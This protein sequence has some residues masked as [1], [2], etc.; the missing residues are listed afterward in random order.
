MK[1]QVPRLLKNK[2]QK[3]SR[4]KSKDRKLVNIETQN[5]KEKNL[6]KLALSPENRKSRSTKNL[7]QTSNSIA[8]TNS[9]EPLNKK[10]LKA[11]RILSQFSN[12]DRFLPEN[13]Q[14]TD[15]GKADLQANEKS[16]SKKLPPVIKTAKLAYD[17]ELLRFYEEITL[18]KLEKDE[19]HVFRVQSV[20]ID[21]EQ[22]VKKFIADAGINPEKYIEF[23]FSLDKDAFY[24]LLYEYKKTETMDAVLAFLLID[25]TPAF[26]TEI[27]IDLNATFKI[28]PRN[29]EI[30]NSD[31]DEKGEGK[32]RF[33]EEKLSGVQMANEREDIFYENKFVFKEV[34]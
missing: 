23:K 9:I 25:F 11:P 24:K 15:Q 14:K 31:P 3:R 6:K 12:I 7:K 21:F 5:T 33:L 17:K 29:F 28:D 2:S 30:G 32:S 34:A 1:R 8:V 10:T 16:L 18:T 20:P 26:L 13:D 22:P 27:K 4:R 19:N